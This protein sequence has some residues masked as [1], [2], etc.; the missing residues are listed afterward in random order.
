MFIASVIQKDISEPRSGDIPLSVGFCA[1]PPGLERMKIWTGYYKHGAP[2]ELTPFV[3][4]G[5]VS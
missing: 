4:S 2:T 1:A 3:S 5:S